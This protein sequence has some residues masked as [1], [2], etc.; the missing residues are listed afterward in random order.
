MAGW[1]RPALD[2]EEASSGR[3]SAE[4][5]KEGEQ[6]REEAL[7]DNEDNND[8]RERGLWWVEMLLALSM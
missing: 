8:E 6:V 7:T 5:G 3:G 1:P 2:D 4:Q